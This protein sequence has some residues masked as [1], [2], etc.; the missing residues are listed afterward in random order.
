MLLGRS[1]RLA[2]PAVAAALLLCLYRTGPRAQATTRRAPERSPLPRP[3]LT[4]PPAPSPRPP[5]CDPHG[6]CVSVAELARQFAVDNTLV[7]TFG[8]DRQQHFSVNWVAYMQRLG[9]R[10]LLVGMMNMNASMPSYDGLARQ[11]RARGVG[12][13][14]VNSR[15]V[16]L[17]PQGGR[18]FHVIPL[19]RTGCRVV[20]SD[21]DAVWLRD[22]R[23]YLKRLERLHPRMD[24]SVSTDAQDWTDGRRLDGAG[25][26]DP[27]PSRRGAESDA[28][29]DLDIENFPHCWWSMNIGIMHFPPGPREGEARRGALLAIE[30]A[31]RHMSS[32]PLFWKR[33]WHY[34]DQGPMNFRW[35]LGAGVDPSHNASWRWRRP[36][37]AVRDQ[38]GRRLCGMVNGSVVAGILPAAQFCNGQTYSVFDLPRLHKVA[39][40]VVHAV[41]I[42]EQREVNKLMRLREAML[43]RDP[44]EWYSAA[45]PQENISAAGASAARHAPSVGASIPAAGFITYTPQ[46]SPELLEV[47]RIIRGA[48]PLHHLRLIHV[49]L[50]QLRNALFIARTLGRALVLPHLQ[51]SCSCEIGF[52]PNH[53]DEGCT[54]GDHK[55]L[56][57]PY[58]CPIDHYLDPAALAKSPFA[59]RERT[60]FSN[61]HTPPTLFATRQSV[62][63]CSP[64][65][66]DCNRSHATAGNTVW[67]QPDPTMAQ[68]RT[69]LRSVSGARVIDFDDVR[70]AFGG[71]D[72][73][74]IA[75]SWH[76][77]AQALLSSWCCTANPQFKRRAGLVPY[78]LPPHPGQSQWRGDP[79]LRWVAAAIATSF[80][81]SNDTEFS[82]KFNFSNR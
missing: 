33:G 29:A 36:L 11:L 21:S 56:R 24:F 25:S 16:A 39:P 65:Y 37:H 54:A 70:H 22:P 6:Q 78:L 69:A 75:H 9:V 62:Q 57:L 63:V 38:S 77:D 60:F 26:N 4:P 51:A 52:W 71:F 12:V 76:S 5:P 28:D 10:G 13:Y 8:N 67:L 23:P 19:L 18:W 43:W 48:L 81:E 58:V 68:L 49:Q 72:N 50:E 80:S 35:K 61:G 3:R 74:R 15:E 1:I 73:D 53:I 32:D 42:R 64:P 79:L 45:S 31:M 2:V 82:E 44:P 30:E 20:L 27:R 46:I 55:M 17:R 40:F 41:W 66:N 7:V 34:V 47:P 59:H 14:L